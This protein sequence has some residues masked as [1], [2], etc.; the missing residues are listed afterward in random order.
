MSDR[1]KVVYHVANTN[2]RQ[3]SDDRNTTTATELPGDNDELTSVRIEGCGVDAGVGDGALKR[4]RNGPIMLF[5]RASPMWWDP[6]FDS[7]ILERKYGEMS[8]PERQAQFRS[9]LWYVIMATLVW[10]GYYAIAGGHQLAYT[11]A[12]CAACLVACAAFMRATYAPAYQRLQTAVSV[13]FAA[14]LCIGL[15][16]FLAWRATARQTPATLDSVAAF[17]LAVEL[18]L[19]LYSLVPLRLYVCAAFGLTFS[20]LFEAMVA[21]NPGNSAP[22]KVGAEQVV[23]RAL[24]HVALHLMGI[25]I[26]IMAQVRGRSTFLKVCR[27]R[28]SCNP[29]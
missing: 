18:L 13:C 3:V 24:M 19:V 2:D 27:I 23:A 17:T 21:L 9:C 14:L 16:T 28:E 11:G 7:D 6:Q 22:S 5:D 26:Y 10:T 29:F 25:H 20:A 12:A 1:D 15:L 8:F 4:T